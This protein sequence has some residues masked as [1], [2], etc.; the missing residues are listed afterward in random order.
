[1]R[2]YKVVVNETLIIEKTYEIMAT[3]ER[4]ARVRYQKDFSDC[5]ET[6]RIVEDEER[7]IEVYH[8]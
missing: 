8:V 5:Y 6:D 3:D 7:I 2:T 1:M 4:D